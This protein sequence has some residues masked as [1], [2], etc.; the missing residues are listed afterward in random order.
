[1]KLF[2]EKALDA[3]EDLG[4]HGG[5]EA[6]GLGVLLAGVVDAEEE[7]RG[8]GELGLCAVGERVGGSRG[9]GAALLQDFEVGVPGDFSEGQDGARLE[10][11]QFAE[12]IVA[13]IRDFGGERLVG[14][15]GT[16]NGGGD[17]GVFQFEAVVAA[18]GSGLIGE[19]GFVEGCEEKIA[20]TVAGE[21]AAGA[22]AAVS[23]GGEPENEELRVRIAE[24][25]DGSAPISPIAEG[26]AFFLG[27]FFAVDNEARALATGD[28]FLI[29][30]A[31]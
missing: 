6:A 4:V 21:D 3:A 11:F 29:Q 12:E 14:G 24:T 9:D 10:D 1:V 5:R 27:D 31:E 28:D 19:A 2:C 7:G 22:V 30:D 8:G 17:V 20:G 16:A 18:D 15:R 13:A 23:G 25:G 26:A